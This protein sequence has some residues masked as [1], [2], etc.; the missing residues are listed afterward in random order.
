MF[1]YVYIIHNAHLAFSEDNGVEHTLVGE[2]ILV[3]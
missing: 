1:F 3:P 2:K